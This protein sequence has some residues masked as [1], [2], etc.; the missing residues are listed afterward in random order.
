MSGRG[1]DGELALRFEDVGKRYRVGEIGART[2]GEEIARG[3]RRLRGRAPAPAA[4][5]ERAGASGGALGGAR[6]RWALRHLELDVRRG[7]ILGVIGANG[8]GKSTLL[9]LLSRITTPTEGRIGVRGRV[10]SLLEVGTGFHPDLTGRENAYLNGAIMGL[11]RREVRDRLS[12]IAEFADCGAYLD[13]PVKRYSS[14][15]LVRLG[16]AVAAHL[17]SDVLVLDE[18]LAVGDAAFRRRS[19]DR[20]RELVREE[21]TT[22]L[23][24]S[25]D[26][27]LVGEL[28][29]RGA[30][31]RDGRARVFDSARA[32][33]ADHLAL[34][35]GAA[36]ERRYRAAPDRPSITALS[37]DEAALREGHLEIAV[38]FASPFA[39][40]PNVGVVVRDEASRPLF[41][42]NM[43]AHPPGNA[44][45]RLAGGRVVCRYAAPPLHEG[46]YDV[47][48]WLS[49]EHRDFDE[50]ADALRVDLHPP[51]RVP[52]PL[53]PEA[54]G[55]LDLVPLWRVEPHGAADEAA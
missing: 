55:S 11:R 40:R 48:V 4:I 21:G 54:R 24:V 28:C 5:D 3:Y 37:V 12:R 13:T 17:R 9:K 51:G 18:V 29:T 53:P 26:M 49:D 1:P 19:V 30:V 27:A 23:F 15:M 7:D 34:E 10:A 22:V 47:S 45:P 14:G 31:L 39:F 43:H 50:K 35:A 36:L 25:H 32:A 42:T 38:S 52:T 20:I 44:V 6:E 8:A 41:G 46:R 2:L 33:I 16:F